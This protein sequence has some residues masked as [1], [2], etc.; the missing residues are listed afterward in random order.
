MAEASAESYGFD[1]SSM[2][3]RYVSP[4]D[5]YWVADKF[6]WTHFNGADKPILAPDG[7]TI[8]DLTDIA[9]R[10]PREAALTIGHEQAHILLKHP[11]TMRALNSGRLIGWRAMADP[12]RR[13][14]IGGCG[15][16]AR[17]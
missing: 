6:G 12:G 15:L 11:T 4:D 10:S 3:L 16:G 5:P 2:D 9:L 7:R 17:R 14:R 13:R 8:T 1:T